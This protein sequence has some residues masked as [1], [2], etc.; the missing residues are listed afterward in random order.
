MCL[1]S[2]VWFFATPWTIA[3]HAHLSME[4][5]RQEYWSGLPFPTPGDLPDQGIEPTFFVSPA[6]AGRFFTTVPPWK[7]KDLLLLFSLSV[8]SNSLWLHAL[9][10]SRLPC[11]SPTPGDCSNSC[12]SSHWCHPFISP[13]VI[14]SPSA[15][16][17]SQHRGL[18]QW[19]RS[20]H[21]VAKVLELQLQ[22]QFFQWIFRIDFL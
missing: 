22:H 12:P 7:P 10:H 6:L 21:Q 5:S 20:S 3:C 19:V 17:L 9:Q 1:R 11:P 4:F 14:P 8:M 18:F 13:S 2:G 15:F 16:N